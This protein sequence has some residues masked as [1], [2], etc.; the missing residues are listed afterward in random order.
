MYQ[1]TNWFE[2]SS[3]C[4][5]NGR[6]TTSLPNRFGTVGL[7]D[8]VEKIKDWIISEN[9]EL[10]RVGIVGMG[11][12]GKTTLAQKIFNDKC[13]KLR[14]RFKKRIWVSV[15]Q[16][17]D[18]V[19][20]M[21]T[22]L[23]GLNVK[24]HSADSI[25]ATLL[26]KI[27]VALTEKR[28]LIIMDDVWSLE[29]GW[30]SQILDGLTQDGR[31]SSCIIITTRNEEVARSMG[32]GELRIHRPKLLGDED[33]WSLLCKVVFSSTNGICRN[34][35]LEEVGKNIAKKCGG[36][37]LAIKAIAG[38]LSIRSRPLSDWQKINADF[39]AKLAESTA[40]SDGMQV[41]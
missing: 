23:D 27:K 41:A 22:I 15:S 14:D 29:D 1:Q 37:P 8:D 21:R 13:Q 2:G 33:S 19:Q 4:A 7:A 35:E 9:N 34:P 12:L 3:S 40:P 18:V 10:Q 5:T 32:V 24:S 17:V 11:G 38:L 28:Y 39:R 30:W 6:W 31:S 20:I 16:L 26:K 36:L 25:P